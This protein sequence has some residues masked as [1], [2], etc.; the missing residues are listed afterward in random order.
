MIFTLLM[1]AT[2]TLLTQASGD[3]NGDGIPDVAEI[4]AA[5]DAPT[6]S[7]SPAALAVYF[8][9][10]AGKRTLATTAPEAACIHCGGM[11]GGDFPFALSIEKGVLVLR[12]F[13][14][15][16][17][18]YSQTTRWRFRDGQFRLIGITDELTDTIASEKG[19]TARIFRD[20]NLSTSKVEEIVERVG[21]PPRK[22]RCAVRDEKY[23]TYTLD[24]FRN[25]LTAPSCTDATLE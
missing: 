19:M 25:D 14:G 9:D 18:A 23:R 24:K 8:V 11:K 1:L 4:T 10:A 15:A 13:G 17:E 7:E 21:S 6:D 2:P 3:L 20:A 12:S 5:V 16:R 22:K